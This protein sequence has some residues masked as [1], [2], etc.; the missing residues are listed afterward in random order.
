MCFSILL[1]FMKCNDCFLVVLVVS[2]IKKERDE[3]KKRAVRF[4]F[5]VLLGQVYTI[6]VLGQ[7][8]S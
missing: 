5:F 6:L 1:N 2:S 4:P 8:W 7:W 3:E